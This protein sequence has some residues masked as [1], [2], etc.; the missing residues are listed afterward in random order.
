[1]WDG[2]NTHDAFDDIF[3]AA[4][5]RKRWFITPP[6]NPGL[7]GRRRHRLRRRRGRCWAGRF[8][9][10]FR[11]LC[12]AP[13]KPAAPCPIVLDLVRTTGHGCLSTFW[14]RWPIQFC[15]LAGQKWC[16]GALAHWPRKP[17]STDCPLSTRQEGLM[18]PMMALPHD[19][20]C[21]PTS[22]ANKIPVASNSRGGYCRAK[23][24]ATAVTTSPIDRPFDRR[25][26]QKQRPA[27]AAKRPASLRA[28]G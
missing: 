10:K 13:Q 9:D 28:Q 7:G 12:V 23:T 6:P 18:R 24:C 14:R 25:A 5:S 2:G 27:G 21:I 3:T 15:A 11:G 8:A 1:M 20:R 19:L 22:L 4:K 26:C 16:H 17:F